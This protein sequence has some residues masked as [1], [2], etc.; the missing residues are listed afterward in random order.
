MLKERKIEVIVLHL[1]K[2]DLTIP[3]GKL[4]M[5][6]LSAVA[7]TERDLLIERTHAGLALAKAEGKTLGRTPKTTLEQ[8]EKMKT[9]YNDGKGETVSALARDYK[10]SRATVLS[11]VKAA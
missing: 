7:E 8:R 5:T 11:I 6:M 1:G 9:G 4:M 2:L 10:V 3:A